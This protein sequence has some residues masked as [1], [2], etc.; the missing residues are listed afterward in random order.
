M[1]KG[2]E[3]RRHPS[4]KPEIRNLES[5][6]PLTTT[7]TINPENPHLHS[8]VLQAPD[9]KIMSS[10]S[11]LRGAP[12]TIQQQQQ[13]SRNAS[14]GLRYPTTKKTIYDRNLN[15]TKNAELSRAAF[16]YLFV[17]MISYAQKRVKGIADLEARYIFPSLPF[18][19]HHLP[20]YLALTHKL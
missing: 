15:R 5:I 1:L 10:P 12:G 17:E 19:N 6:D 2:D 11:P 13:T 20:R 9:P 16:A 8:S 14:P 4:I 3:H 18:P 7:T